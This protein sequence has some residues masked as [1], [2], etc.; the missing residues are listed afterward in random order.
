VP[1]EEGPAVGEDDWFEWAPAD[2]AALFGAGPHCKPRFYADEDVPERLVARMRENGLWV[3][4]VREEGR[5]GRA[6]ADHVSHCLRQ[7]W[8]LLTRDEDFWSE[9]KYPTSHMQPGII[10]LSAGDEGRLEEAMKWLWVLFARYRPG[11]RWC[12]LKA[13]AEPERFTLRMRSRHERVL[14]HEFRRSTNG[15]LMV[16][17]RARG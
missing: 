17:E 15:P 5:L 3:T 14:E 6:D 16:R 10:V 13:R 11:D 1:Q 9:R 7:G 2:F 4:T 8:V 12:G